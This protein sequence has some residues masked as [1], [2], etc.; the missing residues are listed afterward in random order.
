MERVLVLA[1]RWLIGLIRVG[2]YL[3]F[4]LLFPLALVTG[5][6]DINLALLVELLE[7][8]VTIHRGP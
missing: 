2:L 7:H 3:L 4:L 5:P 6:L 8:I 1:V